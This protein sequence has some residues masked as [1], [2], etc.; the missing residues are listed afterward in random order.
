QGYAGPQGIERSYIGI[1]RGLGVNKVPIGKDTLFGPPEIALHGGGACLGAMIPARC[2]FRFGKQ[3][4]KVLEVAFEAVEQAVEAYGRVVMRGS[5][6]GAETETRIES[7]LA[8][9]AV[10]EIEIAAE[11][12]TSGPRTHA[13]YARVY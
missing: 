4:G 5:V 1:T 11:P 10:T 8:H 7:G 3:M 9:G 13:D 2:V 6:E 12:V